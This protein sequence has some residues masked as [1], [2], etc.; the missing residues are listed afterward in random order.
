MQTA[1]E[2][3]EPRGPSLSVANREEEVS[4]LWLRR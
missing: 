2:G 4:R 1:R 3:E